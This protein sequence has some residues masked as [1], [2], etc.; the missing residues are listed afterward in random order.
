MKR[1]TAILFAGVLLFNL[2]GYELVFD[3]WQQQQEVA[4]TA[5]LDRAEYADADLISI[6]TPLSMPYYTASMKFERIDGS[7]KIDGVE[8][9]YVKRRIVADSLE[10]LC[11]P[12]TAKQKLQGAKTDFFKLSNDIQRPGNKKAGELVKSLMPDFYDASAVYTLA[13]CETA[14]KNLVSFFHTRYTTRTRG[15]AEHPPQTAPGLS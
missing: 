3:I 7:I 5:R 9:R 11:L 2:W 1:F 8:Y 15:V 13:P 10:L 4:L 12:N 6:K 14:A